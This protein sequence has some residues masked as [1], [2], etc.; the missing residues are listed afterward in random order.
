MD[1][2]S[3]LNKNQIEAV[4]H[5]EGPALVVAGPGSGKTRVL[6]SRAA[7]L[8][9][10]QGFHESNILIVTFTNKAA[11]EIQARLNQIFK[12]DKKLPWAGT[13]HSICS[14][15]L[16]RDGHYIGIKPSFAIY[17]D[18]D[19]QSVIKGI[20]KEMNLP[21]NKINP[22]AVLNKISACK[23]ELM[24]ETE[25]PKYAYGYFQEIVAKVYPKYQKRLE[26]NNALDFD[27]IIMKTVELFDKEPRV[28]EKYQNQFLHILID[29][30]QDTN[31]AQYVLSK[32]LAAKHRNI[33][34]VGDMSQA[35][36]SFRGADFRNIL[37]FEKDY[38]D[39]KVYNLAQNYRSTKNI[40]NAAKS[41]IKKN[42]SHISLELW[43]QNNE[44][45]R[46]AVYE[47]YNE[48]DEATFVVNEIKNKILSGKYSFSDFA[49]LYRTNAQSRNIEEAFIKE[50]IP[51]KLIG[52]LR[53]YS[54]KEIKDLIAYLR[55]IVNPKDTVS[56]ERII[57]VPPRGLGKKAVE[58]FKEAKWDLDKITELTKLPFKEWV[59]NHDKYTALETLE[60]VIE[61]TGY[62]T[63]LNDGSEENLYRIENIKELRSVASLFTDL[64][65]FLENVALI[66][67][68]DKPSSAETDG[69]TLMTIHAAKGLEFPIVFLVGMEEGLFP[70]SR[71]LLDL[72]E[73][74]EERRLCYVAITRAKEKLNLTHTRSRLYFGNVQSNIVSRFLLELPEELLEMKFGTT[75]LNQK[76][77]KRPNFELD[78][79]LDKLDG[80]RGK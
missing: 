12:E 58:K 30:Y 22:H 40:I 63:W 50:G 31:K 29:E 11:K 64:N 18:D 51:Y 25:F 80:E 46:I 47:A 16:R 67:S 10:E 5:G 21:A 53:F 49:V 61:K 65:E 55:V 72:Q 69:I 77:G 45:D 26:E 7:Y 66:E 4:K 3:T 68:S 13:F 35:I 76:R 8:I 1:L 15:I 20:L 27:D 60:N 44:G 2:F 36:Y 28:L 42:A 23:N 6:T 43:T 48:V 32:Q 59:E 71:S 57:N 62:I 54:R 56:W 37:N 70:H 14:K 74:E 24:D 41:L 9:K 17:D 73:L 19:Q 38:K 34:V 79:F 39:A 78:D 33:F 75:N 52:G